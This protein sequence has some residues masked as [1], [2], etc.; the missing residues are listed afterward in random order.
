VAI[1]RTCASATLRYEKVVAM[2]DAESDR[3]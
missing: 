3:R 2:L 1:D